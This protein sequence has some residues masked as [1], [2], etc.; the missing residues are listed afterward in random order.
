[1]QPIDETPLSGRDLA[2]IAG[3]RASL[4][5]FL[6]VPFTTLPDLGFVERIRG[7]EFVSALGALAGDEVVH[8]DV[9]AG[10]SLMLGYIRSTMEMEEGKLLEELGVDRTRLYR[11]VAPGYGPPPPCEAVWSPRASD[12]AAVLRELAEIYRE[13]GMALSPE[14][15][16][17]L[18]YIG[19]EMEYH[20]QLAMREAEAWE[21]GEGEKA[22]GL[23]DRQAEFLGRHVG[24]WAPHFVEKA[25]SM[26]ETDFYRGHLM[27]L[28]G[29]LAGEL[30]R[31]RLLLDDA[32]LTYPDPIDVR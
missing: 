23:L 21:A 8:S 29:F 22:R 5:R 6:N 16:E 2:E 7:S 1:M 28:R 18:D 12:S 14:A 20:Q 13:A 9:A 27:M 24:L 32:D 15:R 31:I 17:R 3:A 10:A 25:L 30:E 19:V 4:C 11:G 26:A